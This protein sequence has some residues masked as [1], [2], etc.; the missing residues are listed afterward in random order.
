MLEELGH[1]S[2]SHGCAIRSSPLANEE[3]WGFIDANRTFDQ[4]GR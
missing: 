1:S 3:W 2:T 4:M